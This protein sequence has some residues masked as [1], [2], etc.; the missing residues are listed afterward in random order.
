MMKTRFGDAATE[1]VAVFVF[2]SFKG[3]DQIEIFVGRP[4]FAFGDD[5]RRIVISGLPMPPSCG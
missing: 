1:R 5:T 4:A 3:D 2:A